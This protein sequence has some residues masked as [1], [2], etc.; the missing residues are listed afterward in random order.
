VTASVRIG[1]IG[2]ACRDWLGS[3]YPANTSPQDWLHLYAERLGAVEIN[4]TIHR[5]PHLETIEAWV[6]Q[7][8]EQF[9]LSIAVTGH[10]AF[11]WK[12]LRSGKM[13]ALLHQLVGALGERA[14]PVLFQV[15]SSRELDLH[16][17][18]H[19]LDAIEGLPAAVEFRHPSWHTDGCLRV[20]SK[21][22]AAWVVSDG[23]VG[24]P[25]VEVTADFAYWRLRNAHSEA[26]WEAWAERAAYLATRGIELYG[27][28]KQER[29]PD[30]PRRA[31]W[32]DRRVAA[33][34]G[35]VGGPS[36]HG[37]ARVLM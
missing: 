16:A 9:R 13:V 29:A 11:D 34:L 21:H 4:P 35:H 10:Q 32:L 30:T 24:Q 2:L 17:L 26:D 28:V 37:E 14:G 27:Y 23:S 20:L 3:F 33:L 7:V 15:P 25:R 5:L 1:M 31:M 12:H 6:E 22:G 18:A 19:F 36:G 8:P